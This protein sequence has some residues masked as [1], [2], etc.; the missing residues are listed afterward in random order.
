MRLKDKVAIITGGSRGIGYATAKAFL[1]E[2]AKV[3]I[4][5]SKQ[6]NAD[7]A[8][9]ALKQECDNKNIM[10]ISPKLDSTNDVKQSFEKVVEAFGRIDIL[11]NNA[12]LSESTPFDNYT[13]E[14]FD[15]IMDLNVKGVSVPTR[16]AVEYMKEQASGVVLNTSSMVMLLCLDGKTLYLHVIIFHI[17]HFFSYK[18]ILFP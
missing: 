18:I 7:R 15:K 10:G 3:A 4:T 9:E 8:V 11:V 14:T 1:N 17:L 6:E 5:A 2:G 12:G 13:E 16:V